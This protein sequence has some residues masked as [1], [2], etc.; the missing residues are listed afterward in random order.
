M[1]LLSSACHRLRSHDGTLS[2][3]N[4]SCRGV[5]SEGVRKL[6]KSCACPLHQN[7][8][9]T[10]DNDNQ[11][12]TL[13]SSPLVALWLEGNEIYPS[14]AKAMREILTVSPKL[15]YLYMSNNYI[16]DSGVSALAPAFSQCDVCHLG[17]NRIGAVGALSIAEA[18]ESDTS[19]VKTLVLDNNLLGD[20]GAISIAKSLTHNTTLKHLDLRYNRIG[21]QGIC[22]FLDVL[23][24]QGNTTLECLLF[25]EDDDDDDDDDDVAED[26]DKKSGSCMRSPPTRRYRKCPRLMER[27][28]CPCEKCRIRYEMQYYLAMNRAGRSELGDLTIAS[29]LWPRILSKVS[30][31]EPSLLF[32]MLQ[33]RPDVINR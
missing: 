29:S 13:C 16:G 11:D 32:T 9:G 10:G 18:L 15:K 23:K 17:D 26:G 30:K 21:K 31:D 5:G 4:L 2:L 25:E 3:L 12:V 28:T 1:D 7:H 19:R 24:E 8:H 22:A 33:L 14:G 27:W 6:S 20:E